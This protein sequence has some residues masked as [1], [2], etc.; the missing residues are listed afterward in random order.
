MECKF[1]SEKNGKVFAQEFGPVTTKDL[2]DAVSVVVTDLLHD[3]LERWGGDRLTASA[4][5]PPMALRCALAGSLKGRHPA[6]QPL[7][8]RTSRPGPSLEQ[9]AQ[10]MGSAAPDVATVPTGPD[11]S[12]R[13]R[14]ATDPRAY[15]G[16][17]VTAM[18]GL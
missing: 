15:S 11:P 14:V 8:R 6:G 13:G 10:S 16:P 1:L 17:I 3:A 18:K 2:Y 12:A 9:L 5:G 7:R 4:Y